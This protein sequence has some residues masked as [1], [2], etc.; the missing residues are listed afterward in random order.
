[1]NPE[2]KPLILKLMLCTCDRCLAVPVCHRR[3]PQRLG[4]PV[5]TCAI[6]FREVFFS[7]TRFR[8]RKLSALFTYFLFLSEKAKSWMLNYTLN[9]FDQ[10]ASSLCKKCVL[11]ATIWWAIHSSNQWTSRFSFQ[12]IRPLL[13]NRPVTGQMGGGGH[14]AT[15][16]TPSSVC[17]P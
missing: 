10:K 17:G 4:Q 1:M 9:K 12:I 13:G 15:R 16:S 2:H 6:I 7:Q 14:P 5:Q 3:I 8:D 11:L